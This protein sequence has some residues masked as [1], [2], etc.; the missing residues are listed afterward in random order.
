MTHSVR[1]RGI[2]TT[3]QQKQ[4][5]MHATQIADVLSGYTCKLNTPSSTR[6]TLSW[7][8]SDNELQ[9]L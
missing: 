4:T 6:E 5:V 1:V 8:T 3:T 9:R 7:S 2:I